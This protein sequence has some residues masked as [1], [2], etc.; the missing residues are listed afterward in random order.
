MIEQTW[1]DPRCSREGWPPGEWDGEPDKAQWKDEATGVACLAKRHA[2]SGHWCGY[3]GIAAWHPWHG[4]GY[5]DVE[6]NTHGGLTFAD[7]CEEGPP[8]Q[9]VCHI[10]EPGEPD[11]L[12][13]LGFD[14]AHAWDHSPRDHVMAR[15]HGYPFT[16]DPTSSY[17]SLAYVKNH[18]AELAQQVAAASLV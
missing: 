6:V 3:V 11:N 13:W 4:K 2:S 1:M 10:P 12:W 17:K 8:E 9:T 15:E 5:S 7:S 18:C 16:I 14:C